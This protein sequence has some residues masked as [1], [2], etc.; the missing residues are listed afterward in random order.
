MFSITHFR[1]IFF[2]SFSVSKINCLEQWL[3]SYIF[4][5]VINLAKISKSFP[6]VLFIGVFCV[7]F[8]SFRRD[9]VLLTNEYKH[10]RTPHSFYSISLL[11]HLFACSLCEPIRSKSLWFYVCYVFVANVIY[12]HSYAIHAYP[13]PSRQFMHFS[14]MDICICCT[15]LSTP[16]CSQLTMC[17]PSLR[18][19]YIHWS[20]ITQTTSER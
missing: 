14:N 7:C 18:R 12:R 16:K 13:G 17:W 11:V 19:T 4:L 9:Y 5:C 3:S 10:S 20:F 15:H 2:Q 8:I 1:V 6:F